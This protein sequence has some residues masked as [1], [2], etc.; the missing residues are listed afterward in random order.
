MKVSVSNGGGWGSLPCVSDHMLE[1]IG[2]SM[3]VTNGHS[4]ASLSRFKSQLCYL[5]IVSPEET[6]C[7]CLSFSHL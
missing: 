1:E 7:L 4:G 6:I 2:F 3:M 5:F